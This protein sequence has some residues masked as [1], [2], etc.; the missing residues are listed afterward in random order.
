MDDPVLSTRLDALEQNLKRVR[1]EPSKWKSEWNVQKAGS[2]IESLW[3]DLDMTI[4][5]QVR[6]Q[7]RDL[8]KIRLKLDS[9]KQAG[10]N[11]AAQQYLAEAWHDYAKVYQK[12]QEVFR[13]CLEFLGG[14]AFRDKYKDE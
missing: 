4:G 3:D 7:L 5:R 6:D 9:A 11:E 1:E 8:R 2:A 13:E 14:L 12:C 10:D